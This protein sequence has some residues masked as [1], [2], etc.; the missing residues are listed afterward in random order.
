MTRVH[1]PTDIGLC[2]L[3]T[4]SMLRKRA[5]RPRSEIR[6]SG[7][8][9]PPVNAIHFASRTSGAMS[10]PVNCATA[11]MMAA[12]PASPPT[13]KYAGTSHVHTGGFSKGALRYVAA[14][15]SGS[16]QAESD[17]DACDEAQGGGEGRCPSNPE[18]DRRHHRMC[19]QIE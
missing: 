18:V 8:M 2:S 13:K 11:A 3:N 1:A 10:S 14:M 4:R 15:A 9:R 17:D 6:R 7:E 5:G 12:A 16:V 19:G